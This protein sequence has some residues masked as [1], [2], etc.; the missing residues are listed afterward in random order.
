MDFAAG[1]AR[2]G[3][4]DQRAASLLRRLPQSQRLATL[5]TNIGETLK[6]KYNI[7]TPN[8]NVFSYI[9]STKIFK[10]NFLNE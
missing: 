2:L 4:E 7:Q 6:Y 1:A 3:R 9:L 8:F 5:P 10:S